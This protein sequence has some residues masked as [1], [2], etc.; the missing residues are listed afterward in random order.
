MVIYMIEESQPVLVE[1]CFRCYSEVESSA[2]LTAS[3]GII[4]SLAFNKGERIYGKSGAPYGLRPRNGWVLKK[5]FKEMR[6]LSEAIKVFIDEFKIDTAFV[7][8]I[9]DLRFNEIE[10]FLGLFG[11]ED[12]CDFWVDANLLRVLGELNIDFGWSFYR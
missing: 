8:K 1:I 6:D 2:M 10:M 5:E 4:P 12:S 9:R 7:A 11:F 3:L